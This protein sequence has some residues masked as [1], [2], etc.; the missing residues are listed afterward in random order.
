MK[1][2]NLYTGE[3]IPK[4]GFGTWRIGGESLPD[5]ASDS[6]S[7]AA[8]RSALELG[9]THFDT[10]E[11]YAGGH[12]EELLG[13]VI[14]ELGVNRKS[15]FIASKVWQNHLKYDEILCSCDNSLR[16]L[17]MG[18]LDLYLIHWPLAEMNMK[19]VCRG[20]NRLVKDNKVR[21]V[22]VSNFNV[23]LMKQMQDCLE[24]PLVTNQVPYGLTDRTYVD[25]KVLE[26]CRKNKILLTAYS[27]VKDSKKLLTQTLR[28]IAA[29]HKA[30]PYQIA[31]AWIVQQPGVITI[32]MS[33][34]VRH[35]TENLAA[36]NIV[37]SPAE[38]ERLTLQS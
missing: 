24:S 17:G 36:Q 35:Q 37:L 26:Y 5:P 9:Y 28:D 2:E 19:E 32:P 20:L 3:K 6:K 38:M 14:Q 31:I 11:I 33:F 16:R 4:I 29:E 1:T 7:L 18:Y 30:T 8:L 22:G 23:A 21:Y 10:A 13:R 34:N 15:L 12:T 25:N 27:P